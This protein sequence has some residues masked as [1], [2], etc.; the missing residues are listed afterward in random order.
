MGLQYLYP[1]DGTKPCTKEP[2]K[3]KKDGTHCGEIRKVKDG[4]QYFA[5]GVKTG[6]VIFA[7]V[8]LVQSHLQTVQAPRTKGE[9]ED[10]PSDDVLEKKV[11][12]LTTMLKESE[13]NLKGSNLALERATVLLQAS[14]DLLA[15]QVESKTNLN[16]LESTIE[17]DDTETDGHTLVE[18]LA[19]FLED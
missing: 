10:D 17:Y 2:L 18:D 7:N 3:V 13:S 9:K 4:F 11:K 14:S 6:G 12:N 15:L 5:K 8:S 16:L 1:E 19:E